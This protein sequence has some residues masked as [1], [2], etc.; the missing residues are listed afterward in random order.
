M[1]HSS[2][3]FIQTENSDQRER[4]L[5]WLKANVPETRFRHIL[6]VEAMAIELAHCHNLDLK[7]AAQ[8]GLMH[9]LAKFFKPQRLLHMAQVEGLEL[10]PIDEAN[11]HLL[12][13]EVGAIVARDEFGVQDEE[14]L[15]AIRN[16]TL[17]RPGMSPLS[18][19]VYLADGLE[20]GRGSTP[21][22]DELRQISQQNLDQA[23][24]RTADYSLKY[25]L[26]AHHLIHPRAVLTRNWFLRAA[27][28]KQLKKSINIRA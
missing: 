13:A 23:I 17:G 25:L 12:H 7:Q 27:P 24:W 2:N 20:P 5:T 9:D 21:E 26:E 28:K 18:C 3:Q 16:H 8:A 15:Q 19:V 6:R 14:V 1:H 22:L 11:P 10:D 4:I